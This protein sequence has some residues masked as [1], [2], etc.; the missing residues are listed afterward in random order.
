MY[1]PHVICNG[2]SCG[3]LSKKKKYNQLAEG[4]QIFVFWDPTLT[5]L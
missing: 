4:Q 2:D 3:H 1:L 5:F